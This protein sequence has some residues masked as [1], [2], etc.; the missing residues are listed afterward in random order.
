[1]DVGGVTVML[2]ACTKFHRCLFVSG[3]AHS[4]LGNLTH[5]DVEDRDVEYG[6]GRV[7]L[8]HG[9]VA[10]LGPDKGFDVQ[11]VMRED[12]FP[13]DTLLIFYIGS[14][15]VQIKLSDLLADAQGRQVT[16][17]SEL[18]LEDANKPKIR[19][20]LDIG[21]RA[22]SQVDRSRD[23]PGKDVTVL[24]VL[25]GDNV[26]VVGDA[27]EMSS[28][29]PLEHFDAFLSVSVFEHLLMPWK[30][31]IELNRVLKPRAFGLV[32]THQTLGMHD[33]PWDFWRFSDTA[34]DAI[35]NRFTGF[36]IVDRALTHPSYILPFV[37]RD[38]KATAEQAVGFEGSSLIV[39]KIGPPQ[40]SWDV[41]VADIVS[42]IYPGN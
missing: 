15:A 29:L 13:T 24:D 22:R 41:G 26:T 10:T 8:L 25:P 6:S 31:A 20:V 28:Q 38:D 11:I 1:M 3:W 36:E 5:I 7:G 14:D 12:K 9:G 16:R 32:H 27:H 30:V 42:T 2:D 40:V 19:T 34:W 33:M 35:F 37:Y 39:R 17:M 21:G 4:G 23:F 18:F